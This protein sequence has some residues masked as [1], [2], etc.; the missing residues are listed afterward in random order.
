MTKL[1]GNKAHFFLYLLVVV[2]SSHSLAYAECW[3]KGQNQYGQQFYQCSNQAY[4]LPT[5]GSQFDQGNRCVVIGPQYGAVI[6]QTPQL[7]G[8]QMSGQPTGRT[9][10]NAGGSPPVNA[11]GSWP[12]RAYR[13]SHER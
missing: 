6:V 12:N 7:Q 4:N 8:N 13:Y 10:F 11:G 2:I 1:T 9:P 3:L 5:C